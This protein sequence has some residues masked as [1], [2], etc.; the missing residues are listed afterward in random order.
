MGIH[1]AATDERPAE[2]NTEEIIDSG[3]FDTTCS[4][5]MK[6]SS[7]PHLPILQLLHQHLVTHNE[8]EST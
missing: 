2:F 5:D 4:Q 8:I 3:S 6:N 1:Y 7:T